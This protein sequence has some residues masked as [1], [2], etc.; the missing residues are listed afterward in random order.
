MSDDKRRRRRALSNQGGAR[1]GSG[2]P[3][4]LRVL[5]RA[6]E[7]A[8]REDPDVDTHGVHAWPARLHR[9]IADEVLTLAPPDARVLDPFCGSGTA[10]VEA[11]ARGFASAGVD[12]NPLALRVAEVKCRTPGRKA[13]ARFRA[14]LDAVTEAS[15]ER[16]RKKAPSRA[17]LSREEV[18]FY[19]PHVI[20]E[21]GG[22]YEEIRAVREKDDR[23]AL[24]VLLSSIVVKFSRQRSDTSEQEVNKRIG[25]FVPSE[26]FQRKGHELADRWRTLAR[27]TPRGAAAPALFEG[28]ARS[29]AE[30]GVGDVDLVVTS[31][32]YGG[33]Y[34]Y[35]RHHARRYPWL[36]LDARRFDRGE[37]G[38]RRRLSKGRSATR[39][40]DEEVSAFL[41]SIAAVLVP[42]GRAVLLQGD[43]DVG[44]QRV[45]AD[46]QLNELAPAHGLVVLAVA[47]EQRPDFR[48]GAPRE[49]HLIALARA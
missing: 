42:G 21:L 17:P 35:V 29:L 26:F 33:T 23:R 40:W 7:R 6:F 32:P 2:D 20:K 44:G 48:G 36:G 41:A 47:S 9:S 39:E 28:D 45:P 31:P 22:L 14:T 4:V 37:I 27:R 19:Q 13:E 12:L 43:G 16:V 10:L 11:R 5:E 46:A 1:R 34:D 38:A 30:L 3:D 24:L 18:R 49:E 25:R 8:A 15:K